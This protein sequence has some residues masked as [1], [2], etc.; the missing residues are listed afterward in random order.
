MPRRNLDLET[1]TAIDL[2]SD[3]MDPGLAEAERD[4]NE[5]TNV[6]Q[7]KTMA[8]MMQPRRRLVQEEELPPINFSLV[9]RDLEGNEPEQVAR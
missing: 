3:E 8:A 9:K 6:E 4:Y 7:Y 1:D 5:R 2:A